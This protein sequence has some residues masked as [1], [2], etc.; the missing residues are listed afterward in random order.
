MD[1]AERTIE[2]CFEADQQPRLGRITHV[3]VV[4]ADGL[5]VLTCPFGGGN[6]SLMFGAFE[7]IGDIGF[8]QAINS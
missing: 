8:E 4:E 6:N 7:I 3:V 5:K 1:K 2:V